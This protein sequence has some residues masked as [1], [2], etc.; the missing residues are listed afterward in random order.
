V[1]PEE[2]AKAI[3]QGF[4]KNPDGTVSTH[5]M[6]TMEVDGKHVVI[7]TLFPTVDTPSQDQK[8]WMELAPRQ[9]FEEALKRNE[10]FEFSSADEAKKFAEGSWKKPAG[11][12][13]LKQNMMG[14]PTTKPTTSR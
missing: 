6:A 14:A 11:D 8:D 13:L 2:R 4:R 5:L 12:E 3:R 7:P 1:T 9:A 10:V